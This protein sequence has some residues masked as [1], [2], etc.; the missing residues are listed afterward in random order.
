M[1]LGSILK[2]KF[3]KVPKTEPNFLEMVGIYFEDASKHM[4]IP[5]DALEQI[6]VPN[7]T[8]KINLRVTMDDGTKRVF[9]SW[10]C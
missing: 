1:L 9:P 2:H 8:L 4:K 10:R 6:K 7:T 5:K 3:S